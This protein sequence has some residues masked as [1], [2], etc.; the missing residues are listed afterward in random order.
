M[1]DSSQHVVFKAYIHCKGCARDASRCL[2]G[3]DGV[4]GVAIDAANDII[5]VKGE[6]VDPTKVLNRL[7]KKFRT[8][9]LISPIP[10]P[11]QPEKDP[12]KK[13]E[14]KNVETD[15]F[16][17][18]I[19]RFSVELAG[20][21]GVLRVGPG[22]EHGT[23][24]IMGMIE[25]SQLLKHA[26]KHVHKQAQIVMPE[27]PPAPAANEAETSPEEEEQVVASYFPQNSINHTCAC[28]EMFNDENI[29]SCCVM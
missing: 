9:K 3:F 16:C 22:P 29:N 25:D 23:V 1:E 12:P 21:T 2:K 15:W 17:I 18:E 24:A 8:V 27:E 26:R 6:S 14:V 10:Q 5:V 11:I 20:S 13:E 7:R 28:C 4:E 19:S